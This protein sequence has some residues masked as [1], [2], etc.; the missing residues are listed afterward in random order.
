LIVKVERKGFIFRKKKVE[1]GVTEIGSKLLDAKKQELEQKLHHMQESYDNGDGTQLQS[2]MDANQIW[3]PMMLFSGIMDMMFFTSIM[4]FMGLGINPMES[5]LLGSDSSH[6]DA[7]TSVG[8]THT[9]HDN[10]STTSD[11][12]SNIVDGSDHDN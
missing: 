5:A 10:Q 6:H 12:D 2:H 3:I 4:S 1:V 9:V 11:G 8:A 7:N